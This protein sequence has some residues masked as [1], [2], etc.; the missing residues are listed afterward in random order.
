MAPPNRR[1]VLQAGAALAAAIAGTA[2]ASALGLS[3]LALALLG[4]LLL[5]QGLPARWREAVSDT[6]LTLP[7]RGRV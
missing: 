2:W 5:T 1:D 4:G 7:T 6:H 3:T